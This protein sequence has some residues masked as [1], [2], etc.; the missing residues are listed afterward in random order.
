[1]A[2]VGDRIA[3]RLTELGIGQS[4]L[5]RR[6]G[7]RQQGI[8]SI[9][10][11]GVERPRKLR[12]L[13]ISLK[14]TQEYLLG[15][16]DDP[17]S[18]AGTGSEPKEIPLVGY[19]GAGA[20]AHFYA[21]G[22]GPFDLVPAPEGATENTVAVEVRGESLGPLFDHWLV[23]YDE[24]RSPVTPDLIGRL[25]VVGLADDRVLVK[26]LKRSRTPGYYHLLSNTEPTITDVE[27]A[28]AAKVRTMMPR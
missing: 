24:V 7:M 17:S 10:A 13:A 5:A 19:V 8:Q 2:I 26:L 6:V 4:E 18:A 22:Q 25:C 1:M 11:G 16:T 3:Q 28:W 21:N 23:F 15:E 27:V 12:E 20:E 14:T 9:I